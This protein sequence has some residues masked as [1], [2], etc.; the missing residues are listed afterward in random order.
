MPAVRILPF[1]RTSRWAIVSSLTRKAWATT[2]VGSEQTVRSVSATCASRLSAGWQQVK[3]RRS[4]SSSPNVSSASS[5]TAPASISARVCSAS[6]LARKATRRR[7]ASIAFR[8]PV[9]TSQA[10]GLAGISRVQATAAAANASCNPS[11]ARS[12]SPVSRINV[13]NASA[14]CRRNARSIA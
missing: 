13:A 14:A 11:S 3:M 12:K 2:G 1:A 7:T 10:R 6:V 4:M 9:V 5:A 8:R